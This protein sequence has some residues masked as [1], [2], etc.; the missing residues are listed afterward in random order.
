MRYFSKY[1]IVCCLLLFVGCDNSGPDYISSPTPV[2]IL[3]ASAESIIIAE[4]ISLDISVE[5]LSDIF[6]ISFE[7]S[8]NPAYLEL[9]ATTGLND[10]SGSATDNDFF[11]PVTHSNTTEG[12]FSFVMS[13]D[14]IEGNIYTVSFTGKN[15]G[16]SSITLGNVHLVQ[17]DGSPISN[18]SS[19]SL[20]D[21]IT[22]IVSAENE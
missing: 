18:A 15:A 3:S 19:F 16:Q 5:N 7:I 12:V 8:Y 13:G 21:P 2:V 11:G 1:S 10:Y 6:G 17:S 14:N 4:N 20:P 9:V 22:I